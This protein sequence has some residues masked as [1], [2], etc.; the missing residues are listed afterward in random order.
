MKTLLECLE[1]HT[2]ELLNIL[3]VEGLIIMPLKGLGQLN[4]SDSIT[5]Q[6]QSRKQFLQLIENAVSLSRMLFF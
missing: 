3:L 2:I 5:S 1:Q 4:S 6:L